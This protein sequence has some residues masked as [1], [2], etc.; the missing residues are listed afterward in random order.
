MTWTDIKPY[1]SAGGGSFLAPVMLS[2]SKSEGRYRP[3]LYIVLRPKLWEG[4]FPAWI[5]LGARL[6]VQLGTGPDAGWLRLAP[7][8]HHQVQRTP[9]GESTKVMRI[10]IPPLPAQQPGKQRPIACDFDFNDTWVAIELPTWCRPKPAVPQPALSPQAAR[11]QE[12]AA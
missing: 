3:Q 7:N 8:G 2:A 5:K 10:G 6:A 4:E 12:R 9:R 1:A 11:L